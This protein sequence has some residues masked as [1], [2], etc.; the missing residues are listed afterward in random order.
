MTVSLNVHL[1]PALFS[2]EDVAGG[3]VVMVDILRASTTMT[4]ALVH[5]AAQVTPCLTVDEA[6]QIRDALP[7]GAC[8]LGGERGGVK[9]DGFDHGNSPR[10]YTP[11]VVKQK[12]L[13]FTTTNGTKAIHH[14]R[15]ADEI[16]IGCF[17][18]LSS[19]VK[20]LHHTS[21]D[22]HIVCAGTNGD[23]TSE[24]VLFAGCLASRLMDSHSSSFHTSDSTSLAIDHWNSAC[25]EGDFED[26]HQAI[27]AS[28]G[29]RNLIQL[30]FDED[31][32]FV[33]QIDRVQGVAR[34]QAD[35][36]LKLVSKV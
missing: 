24:D 36:T 7:A 29:G 3:V 23:I 2:P 35:G 19:V 21:K 15:Q 33:S 31:I 9:I 11:D 6:V 5:G 16:L 34:M 13:A 20:H 26:L 8:L 30:G 22:V 4:M 14:S 25:G 10:A 28:Q 27:R 17:S 1:L 12:V 18:N 32:R